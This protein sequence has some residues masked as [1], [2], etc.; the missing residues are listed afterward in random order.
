MR[1]F[2]TGATG[3]IGSAIVQEL[4]DAGHEVHGLARSEN[5]TRW[6]VAAGA[7]AH[8]G[9]LENLESLRNGASS[10]DAVIH[11]A[12]HHDFSNY[13]AAAGLD[14]RAI[15]TL[16]DALAGSKRP[17]IITSGTLLAQTRGPL[18]TEDDL[19]NP[20][21][22]RKSEQAAALA[23]ES[24]VNVSVVR[25]PPSVHGEGDHGFVPT[26]IRV[27]SE[28]GVSA[29][30]G[31][32]HNGWPAVHQLDA[33]HLYRLALEKGS[34]GFRYHGVADQSVPAREIAQVIGRHLNI[35]VVSRSREDAV[36][37]FG[38]IGHFFGMDGPASSAQTQKQLG[39]NPTQP[40]LIAD[41][42]GTHYFAE[43]GFS[44]AVR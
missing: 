39:W 7:Q 34:G 8:Q 2:V 16:G 41:L 23:A 19:P 37:H 12:F 40:G 22:P 25:L 32:G 35:P 1:I 17:L 15:E 38:W 30:I 42:D 21:F 33:A 44:I 6:L 20:T 29:Y 4:I 31:D 18:A 43:V 24:G 26:L 14:V 27:A 5:A 3:F 10:A 13:G 36:N 9:S 28:K 11:A